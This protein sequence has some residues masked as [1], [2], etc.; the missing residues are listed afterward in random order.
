MLSGSPVS[1]Y[2]VAWLGSFLIFY[3]SLSGWIKQLPTDLKP[4]EQ[5]MRPL[6]LIQIIFAGYTCCTSIFYFLNTL[7]FD[8]IDS[9]NFIS[10]D[11]HLQLQLTAECQRYYCLGHAA[12]VTG[13]LVFMRYPVQYKYHIGQSKI[14][15]VLVTLAVISLLF[16]IALRFTPGLSQFS[17]QLTS[18]SFIAATLALAYAI[19]QKNFNIIV[20]S[21]F[22]FLSNFS[23]ALLSG[24]K[25]P[26]I[27]S[28]LIL[29]IFLYPSYKKTVIYIFAPVLLSLFM[30]LPTYNKIFRERAWNEDESAD[31]ASKEALNAVLNNTY[32][33]DTNWSFLVFRLSEID[34]FTKFVQS[35]PEYVP[36]YQFQL[37]EQAVEVIVP[38]AFW[39]SKPNT[40]DLVMERVYNAG[41]I[42]RG[43]NVSAKPAY[44]VDAYLSGGGLGVF[45]YLFF[46]GAVSQLIA[47]KAEQLFGG[48]LIGSALV[49]G[50]LF[51]ILWRGL[52]FEFLFNAVFWSFVSMYILYAI[53]RFTHI[54]KPV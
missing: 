27:V 50:G 29:G 16:T 54:L 36:F 8:H 52:S 28:V 13:L 12:L 48:Y 34:M 18:L 41:V 22:L 9:D 35:T 53:F 21:L 51:Q 10:Q 43:S 46:Y 31:N 38:R 44:I 11:N 49:F 37:V 47:R 32:E 15:G 6:F 25:E 19:P 7:G 5:F 23:Q 24:Y 17:N 2:L 1:S 40:E 39:P 45:I 42:Y 26:I 4:G 33:D 14:P 20:V 30:L 3:L